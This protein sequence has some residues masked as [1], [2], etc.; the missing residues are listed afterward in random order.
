MGLVDVC[1]HRKALAATVKLG[2]TGGGRG[3]RGALLDRE[4][5]RVAGCS[6]GGCVDSTEGRLFQFEAYAHGMVCIRDRA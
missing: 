5:I 6:R 4:G 2:Q 3:K 1:G